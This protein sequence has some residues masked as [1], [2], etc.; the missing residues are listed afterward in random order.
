VSPDDIEFRAYPCAEC[1]WRRDTNLALFS[2]AD[3][4]K[5]RAA[6][7]GVITSIN[8]PAELGELLSAPAMAC[9]KDQLDT[10]HPLRLC[11]GWLVAVG[12]DHLW[13]RM[14]ILTGALPASALSPGND[15]PALYTDLDEMQSRRPD[16]NGRVSSNARH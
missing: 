4:A 13:T 16:A 9:H 12:N 6:D 11:A 15:W 7:A 10:A 3:F 2:D 8:D 14:K 1:P 5:L